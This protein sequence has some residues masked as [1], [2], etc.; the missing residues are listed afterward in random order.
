MDV[1]YNPMSHS[2]VRCCAYRGGEHGVFFQ[3]LGGVLGLD[4]RLQA[5]S[6]QQ[7]GTVKG[8]HPSNVARQRGKPS[9]IQRQRRDAIKL[10]TL[11]ACRDLGVF[12]SFWKV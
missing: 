9:Q 3:D 4:C 7:G 12:F 2:C 10:L 6:H 1:L 8:R 11:R 5:A